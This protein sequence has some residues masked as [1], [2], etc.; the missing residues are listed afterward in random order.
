MKVFYQALRYIGQVGGCQRCRRG[1]RVREKHEG[2]QNLQI[3]TC[4]TNESWGRNVLHGVSLIIQL[5]KT[6]PAIQE[7]R[8]D[9]WVREIPWRRDRLPT[10]LFLGFPGGLDGKESTCNVGDLGSISVW[11]NPLEEGMATHSKILTWRI[12]MDRGAWW[13]TVHGVSKSQ[14]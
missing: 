11:E 8:V 6:P 10:P 4:K 9:P 2:R 13:A 3:S 7:T 14:T 5:A 1:S 12:L